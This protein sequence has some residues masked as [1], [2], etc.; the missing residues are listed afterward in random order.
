MAS[1]IYIWRDRITLRLNWTSCSSLRPLYCCFN[2]FSQLQ[3]QSQTG[4]D[5]SLFGLEDSAR[6]QI[7]LKT[8]QTNRITHTLVQIIPI[9]EEVVLSAKVFNV[10]QLPLRL[11]SFRLQFLFLLLR[12]RLQDNKLNIFHKFFVVLLK[13]LLDYLVL[14][15]SEVIVELD[16]AIFV[17]S[18]EMT[19]NGDCHYEASVNILLRK[20][21]YSAAE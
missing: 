18:L 10:E 16:L 20:Y 15:L 17:G 1:E 12:L 9:L 13:Q 8:L 21:L 14:S 19:S 6:V 5:F 3:L 4:L 2:C 7:G 11:Y